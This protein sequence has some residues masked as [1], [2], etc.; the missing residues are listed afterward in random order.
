M[1]PYNSSGQGTRVGRVAWPLFLKKHAASPSLWPVKRVHVVICF[2]LCALAVSLLPARGFGYVVQGPHAAALMVK[3]LGSGA[4]L[5]VKQRVRF[6]GLELS[7]QV[8]EV[9]EQAEYRFPERYRSEIRA[10]GIHRLHVESD[11]RSVT[12]TDDRITS[13]S[14]SVLDGY[15]DLLMVRQTS[16]LIE[17]L[18][19]HGVNPLI[20]SLGRFED[21]LVVIIGARYPDESRPQVWLEMDTYLP[22]RWI[23]RPDD[24][25]EGP[26]EIHFLA[27][28]QV[29]KQWY[30]R[31]I[32]MYENN[33][34]VRD[35]LVEHVST[36]PASRPGDFDVDAIVER[37]AAAMAQQAPEGAPPVDDIDKTIED[38]RKRFEKT[39]Q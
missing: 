16:A 29:N 14:V 38:F 32:E 35:I 9:V 11:G 30:P 22:L 13:R 4:G 34:L 12:V 17:K 36:S 26:F 19:A 33:M 18:A 7:S 10:D 2:V 21:K 1:P 25:A 5:S 8:H 20:S 31:R 39:D 15:K 3:A 6:Y 23:I 27:W 28:Q 37:Y 24:A